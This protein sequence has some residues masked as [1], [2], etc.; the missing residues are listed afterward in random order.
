MLGTHGMEQSVTVLGDFG[1]NVLA[2]RAFVTSHQQT[3]AFL[4]LQRIE[5]GGQFSL[6]FR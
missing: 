1:C 2:W 6:R 5:T 4:K 3:A